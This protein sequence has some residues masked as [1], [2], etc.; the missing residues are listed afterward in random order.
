MAGGSDAVMHFKP[1]LWL[2][3]PRHGPAGAKPGPDSGS[4]N[5]AC[6][7]A[8]K[9]EANAVIPLENFRRTGKPGATGWIGGT[10]DP[11]SKCS[12]I[13]SESEVMSG[14]DRTKSGHDL[15]GPVVILVEPQL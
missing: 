11:D 2:G 7:R 13:E 1:I 12:D 15:A 3:M 10:W 14:T 4:G 5:P 9:S 6:R 8:S